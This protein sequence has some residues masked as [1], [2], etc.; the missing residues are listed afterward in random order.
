MGDLIKEMENERNKQEERRVQYNS[1]GGRSGTYTPQEAND[2]VWSDD[3]G[4][5]TKRQ[6]PLYSPAP[7]D[8]L[9]KKSDSNRRGSKK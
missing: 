4:G 8:K 7:I 9:T 1:F 2:T 5:C 6:H 3:L